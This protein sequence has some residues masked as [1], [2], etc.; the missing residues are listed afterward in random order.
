MDKLTSLNRPYPICEFDAALDME[1][2][3]ARLEMTSIGAGASPDCF[4]WCITHCYFCDFC[5]I[6]WFVG[7]C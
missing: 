1:Q 4:C 5:A 3:E 2:L 7:G 6:C